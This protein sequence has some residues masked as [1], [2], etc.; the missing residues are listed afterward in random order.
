M[1]TPT[2][3]RRSLFSAVFSFCQRKLS[4]K[5]TAHTRGWGCFFPRASRHFRYSSKPSM[6][7]PSPGCPHTFDSK[8]NN[9]TREHLNSCFSF[10]LLTF[11]D[12]YCTVCA[13]LE[14]EVSPTHTILLVSCLQPNSGHLHK[15]DLSPC[16]V[17]LIQTY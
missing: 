3:T 13:H 2:P 4:I 11:I 5:V 1:H 7:N 12:V 8:Q 14:A 15:Q 6:D 17:S 16:R 9:S 10:C